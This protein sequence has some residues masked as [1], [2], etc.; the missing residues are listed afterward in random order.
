MEPDWETA[1]ATT[2]AGDGRRRDHPASG[3]DQRPAGVARIDAASVWIVLMN[4]VCSSPPAVTGRFQ[5]RHA[6]SAGHGA[7]RANGDPTATVGV[8][9]LHLLEPPIDATGVRWHRPSRLPVIRA[10]PYQ[11]CFLAGLVVEDD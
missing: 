7:T 5:L 9:D 8:T 1:L 4:D 11:G 2:Q 3:I 6:D 10:T